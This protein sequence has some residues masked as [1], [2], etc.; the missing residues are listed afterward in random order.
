MR[1]QKCQLE[2]PYLVFRSN[3]LRLLFHQVERQRPN[4]FLSLT[5]FSFLCM[6]LSYSLSLTSLSSISVCLFL[7]LSHSLTQH[8]SFLSPLIFQFQSS[9]D[10]VKCNNIF[11]DIHLL[12]FLNAGKKI[13]RK[14][15]LWHVKIIFNSNFCDDI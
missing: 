9:Y 5:P 7:C 2:L 12:T 4:L 6:C 15:T 1:I 14:N 3:W 10:A 13:K 8:L 11:N